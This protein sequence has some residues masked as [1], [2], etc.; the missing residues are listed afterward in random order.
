MFVTTAF[1]FYSGVLQRFSFISIK[2]NDT[3]NKHDNLALR[4]NFVTPYF[5]RK[6]RKMYL[7]YGDTWKKVKYLTKKWER[8]EF[9][10]SQN[11]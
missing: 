10:F 5:L 6:T 3:L 1:K 9:V 11:V 4:A 2:F 8:N 7:F